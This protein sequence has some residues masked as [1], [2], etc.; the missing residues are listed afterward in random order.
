VDAIDIGLVAAHVLNDFEEHT[1]S[2]YEITG[3][4]FAGLDEV[5][6]LL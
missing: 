1:G 3:S 2:H 6:E 4:E 5:V